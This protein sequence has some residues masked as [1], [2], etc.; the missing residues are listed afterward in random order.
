MVGSE[1]LNGSSPQ[2]K[3]YGITNPISMAGPTETD[4]QRNSELEKVFLVFQVQISLSLSLSL[5]FWVQYIN[6]I[7][8]YYLLIKKI[9]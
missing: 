2:P 8:L 6:Y 5:S 4:L 9:W 7:Y 3:M 1:S